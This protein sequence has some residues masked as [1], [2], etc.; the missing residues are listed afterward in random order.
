MKKLNK[1]D[2]IYIGITLVSF[3][4]LILLLTKNTYLFASTLDWPGQHV[5]IPEY[6]RTLFYSTFD[7][8]PDL[9]LNIGNGQNIYNF[10]YYGLLSPIILISYLLPFISMQTYLIGSSIIIA[11]IS[12]V[13]LYLFLHKHK[14]SSEVCFISSFLF[15]FSSAISFQIHRHIMFVNYMPF[16]ILGLSGVDKIFNEKKSWL[17][18]LSTFLM[19]MTSYYFSIGGILCLFIY[20]LYRYLNHMNKVT[21]KSF[22]K[23]L[24][25]IIV[26]VLVAVLCSAI[27]TI[28]TLSV[29]ISGRAESNTFISLKDLLLPAI[30]TR[31]L[32]Y[33][34]YGIG[35]TAII[36]PAII[37][38]FKKN[39]ANITL[40]IILTIVVIFNIFNYIL[41][42]TM[43]IDGKS[44][45]PLLPVY[46]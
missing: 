37:N 8:F 42:G 26:P 13:M 22:F 35:L 29:L 38:L 3:L 1:K 18:T 36:I 9:A 17:L 12:S 44:L 19:I 5:T 2:Y 46:I 33:Y 23:T 30:N 40:G 10:S 31:S 16:L 24:F 41:N 43:Y 4:I 11:M 45:I 27:I 6:F 32:L 20:A 21:I 25:S 39:K 7:I 15:I 14:Y 34:H 28:P